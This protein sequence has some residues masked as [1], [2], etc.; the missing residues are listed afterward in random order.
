MVVYLVPL[1]NGEEEV[2]IYAEG[3]LM[4]AGEVGACQ[5]MTF[6]DPMV[7]A[8]EEATLFLLEA[9][10]MPLKVWLHID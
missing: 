3:V 2:P 5:W 9:L 10:G 8:V 1:L 6:Q 4:G 7:V